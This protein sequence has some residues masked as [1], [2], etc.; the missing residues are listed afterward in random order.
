MIKASDMQ[1]TDNRF[2]SEEQYSCSVK[3]PFKQE[4]RLTSLYT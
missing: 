1:D 2:L 4:R 3:T